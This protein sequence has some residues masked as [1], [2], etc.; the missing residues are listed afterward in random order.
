MSERKIRIPVKRYEWPDERRLKRKSRMRTL[1]ITIGLVVAFGFGYVVRTAMTPLTNTVTTDFERFEAIFNVL[2]EDWYFSKDLINPEDKLINDAINGMIERS[3]DPHTVYM[4]ADEVQNFAESIDRGF[5]GIGVSYFDNNGT[6]II[7]RVFIDSPAARAGVQ[8]GDIIYTV[9]G[10]STMGLTSDEIVDRV[11]GEENSI[12]T[13]E[14]LR[15]QEI[16]SLDITRGIIAN[17]SFGKM[18]ENEV[19]FLEIYQFGTTTA[20]EVKRYLEVF[21]QANAKKIIIDLRDNGGGYLTSLED[22]GSMF[23]PKDNILIKQELSSGETLVSKSTGDIIL[24]FD[25]ILI[26]VN[27]NTASAAEVFTAAIEENIGSTI[28]G[29][30]TY[31]KGTVQQQRPFS[32]GSALKYTV[33]EWFSPL[34]TKIH[35]VGI[36]PDVIVTQH[37]VMQKYFTLLEADESYGFD[38]VHESIRDAQ[39][40]LDFLDYDVDRTDGYFSEATL[41][42]IIAYL[43]DNNYIEL[44]A[45]VNKELL[46]T[47]RADVVRAWHL[48]PAKDLQLQKALELVNE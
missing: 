3:G 33:A 24:S 26:I 13:I 12:V 48:N 30:T 47:L 9:D 40:A 17:T 46:D 29:V 21:K 44:E 7:E 38:Q 25:E 34:G 35:G 19:A 28:I 45:L 37:E 18:L 10:V 11:R 2:K 27:E 15:G 42:A 6:F 20:N 14:F 31:G 39:F 5:V 4:T 22:V 23:V 36:T 16:V 43:E 8:P 32:D 41:K 1:F